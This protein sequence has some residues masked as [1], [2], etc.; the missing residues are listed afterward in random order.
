MAEL[1]R[2]TARFPGRCAASGQPFGRGA[3]V[4][5]DPMTKRCYLPG[6]EPEGSGLRETP[7]PGEQ[8]AAY[9]EGWRAGAPDA[10]LSSCPYPDGSPERALWWRGLKDRHARG[11]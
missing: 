5:H 8:Q 6:H 3:Y 2:I 10:P 9:G 4:L 11:E 1:V 7:L